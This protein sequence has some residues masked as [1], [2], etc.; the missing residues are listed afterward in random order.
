[1]DRLDADQQRLIKK[2]YQNTLP[3]TVINY[4]KQNEE[5]SLEDL[6]SFVSKVYP[7]LRNTSGCKY[8][9]KNLKKI[10]LGLLSASVF[11]VQSDYISLNSQLLDEYEKIRIDSIAIH[12]SRHKIKLDT[13]P[14][15][16]SGLNTQRVLMIEDF[17]GKLANDPEFFTIFDNPFKVILT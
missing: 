13:T 5:V 1:M 7:S 14:E 8:K 17:C 15:S 3:G 10:V 9:G 2:L 6:M 11:N 16:I 4:I 12:R